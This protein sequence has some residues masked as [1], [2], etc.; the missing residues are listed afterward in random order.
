MHYNKK[1][2]I[3]SCFIC[4][5]LLVPFVTRGDKASELKQK[6]GERNT[7]LNEL[8]Q[9]IA[10]YQTQVE[11]IG[12]QANTLKNNVS[13]LELTRKKL[14]KNIQA[15]QNRIET[16]N[17]VIQ[18][19]QSDIGDKENRI[20]RDRQAIGQTLHRLN[21]EESRSLIETLL[22]YDGLGDFWNE[23]QNLTVLHTNIQSS[24]ND[25][26]DSK[27]KL[28]DSKSQTEAQK[29]Q[30]VNLTLDL[31][32]QTK[33]VETTKEQQA[34]LLAITKNQESNYKKLLNDKL[35]AEQVFRDDLASLE[36]DLKL[37][38]DPKSIPRTGTGVLR[39]PLEKVFITQYFGNTKFATKNPQAYNGLGHN[40]IDLGGSIGSKVTAALSGFIVETGNTGSLS[41][42]YSYGKWILIQH[43]NG[44]STLYAHLSFQGVRAGQRVETGDLIGYSGNTGYVTGPHLHF[45]VYAS[46][47]VR[48]EPLVNSAKCKNIRI[49]AADQKAYLNPLS[50]L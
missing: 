14:L 28:E 29:K 21:T 6:I 33:V 44:L 46:Q 4:L 39:W 24:I 8:K 27:K 49:P 37:I 22:E 16:S 34:D 43:D 40:G 31:K 30:L 3:S 1:Q 45:G 35:A 2:I 20:E 26:N 38:I 7:Q 25:L 36:S 19:L 47:G 5:I 10:I 32:G 9:E 12:K 11:T 13:S 48:V 18:G 23:L 17:L 41:S 42:C 15:T 50:Y